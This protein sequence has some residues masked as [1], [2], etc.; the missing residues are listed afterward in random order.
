MEL[1]V[2]WQWGRKG[3]FWTFIAVFFSEI[4]RCSCKTKQEAR[5]EM[6]LTFYPLVPIW[7]NMDT[8]LLRDSG[9]I[10]AWMQKT[11]GTRNE[12]QYGYEG[13]EELEKNKSMDREDPRNLR[14]TSKLLMIW[15]V[16]FEQRVG[17][18]PLPTLDHSGCKC[19]KKKK[20]NRTKKPK[21]Q[22]QS[23]GECVSHTS[24][25]QALW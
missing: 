3:N 13:P 19:F 5:S 6:T 14:K 23:A 12:N 24:P 25:W 10:Q 8:Y 16:V 22:I 4:W 18:T 11:R 1:D 21:G 9:N 2:V 7:K 20:W 15:D 17:N